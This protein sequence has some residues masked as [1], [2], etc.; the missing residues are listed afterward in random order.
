MLRCGEFQFSRQ[1]VRALDEIVLYREQS[2][3]DDVVNDSDRFGYSTYD[4]Q[5][6]KKT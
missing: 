3:K 2:I 6:W 5:T 4:I 1:I